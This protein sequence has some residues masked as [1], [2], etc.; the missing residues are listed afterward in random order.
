MDVTLNPAKP[1]LVQ[2]AS[3][4]EALSRLAR[5][6][7]HQSPDLR[8]RLLASHFFAAKSVPTVDPTMRSLGGNDEQVSGVRNSLGGRTARILPR[9]LLVAGLGAAATLAW[10]SSWPP[11]PRESSVQPIVTDARNGPATA[12]QESQPAVHAIVEE[13]TPQPSTAAHTTSDTVVSAAT[14]APSPA[15]I[16]QLQAMAHDVASLRQRIEQLT[17]GQEQLGRTIA[18][19]QAAERDTR[20]RRTESQA[21]IPASKPL[22]TLPPPQ[23]QQLPS[24]PAPTTPEG[25]PPRPPESIR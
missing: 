17:A 10:L 18:K 13:A 6:A 11:Q 2:V 23:P 3:V 19:L 22:A 14:P 8:S 20:R 9:I 25:P 7:A 12:E 4:E 15:V 24:A 1:D 16:E 5:Q 21:V